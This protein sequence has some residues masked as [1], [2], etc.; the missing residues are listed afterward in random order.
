MLLGGLVAG[1]VVGSAAGAPFGI[2]AGGGHA[3]FHL[4]VAVFVGVTGLWLLRHGT[5]AFS[6]RLAAWSAIALSAG[7][8]VEGLA[9]IPDGSGEPLAHEVPS[10]ISLVV[11]QPAVLVALVV[12]AVRAL[13]RRLAH[14][15]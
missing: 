8:L 4:V 2:D 10:V 5:A 9:A 11:L 3:I 12:L 13:R 14:S 15:A 7:Q 6:S 1:F